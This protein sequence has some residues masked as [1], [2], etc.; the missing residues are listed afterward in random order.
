MIETG[1]GTE[2]PA[3]IMTKH[4][5]GPAMDAML[6]RIGAKAREG[7]ALSTP[8]VVRHEGENGESDDAENKNEKVSFKQAPEFVQS[9][10]ATNPYMLLAG[11]RLSREWDQD[12]EEEAPKWG[13]P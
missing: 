4:L 2:N 13:T 7:R 6:E 1:K 10:S 12:T 3:E 8:D 5:D 11:E 9:L